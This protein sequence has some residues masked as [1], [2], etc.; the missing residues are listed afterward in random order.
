MEGGFLIHRCPSPQTQKTQYVSL[1]SR[2]VA[3]P[4]D[5]VGWGPSSL[6]YVLFFFI[7][8]A[9]IKRVSPQPYPHTA[10]AQGS[11]AGLCT[12]ILAFSL[13]Q[14]SDTLVLKRTEIP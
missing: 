12:G 1:I 14:G 5:I 11:E 13:V 4:R 7:F 6:A 2:K 10:P 9:I 3:T 8:L